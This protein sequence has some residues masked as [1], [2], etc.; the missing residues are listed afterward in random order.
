[1]KTLIVY[2][3]KGIVFNQLTGDYTSPSDINFIEVVVP[4]GKIV[5]GV[6]TINQQAVLQD[7]PKSEV[8]LLRE[9]LEE[10]EGVLNFLLT[11]GL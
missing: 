9:K 3:D 6:D 11:G 7:V 4:P 1:M 5:T 2:D 8:E 10:T